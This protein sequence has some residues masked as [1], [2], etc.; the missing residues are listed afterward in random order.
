MNIQNSHQ[1]IADIALKTVDAA[2]ITAMSY[3]RQLLDV[4]TKGDESPVTV[5]DK[6]VEAQIRDALLAAYPDFGILGEEH[7]SQNLDAD[8]FWVVDPIDGTRSFISGMPLFGMLLGLV[9]KGK[10]VLGIVGMP[11]LGETYIGQAG[12]GANMNGIPISVSSQTSLATATLF[13]NE[14]ET[15]VSQYPAVFAKLMKAGKIRRMSYDC[16]PHALVAAGHIDAVVDCNLQPYDFLPI[17]A[18]IEAA[19]GLMTD[20]EGNPLTMHSDGRVL[21][22]ATPELLA[23]LIELVGGAA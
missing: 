23:E 13:I 1:Q 9:D 6:N 15:L 4:E 17:V 22:A 19:G 3:F 2:S 7:G 16:Y 5:A 11:A 18:L 21:S 14:T 20:W 8:T 12:I 10:P